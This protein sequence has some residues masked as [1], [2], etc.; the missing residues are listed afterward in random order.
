[1]HRVNHELLAFIG[2]ICIFTALLE[3]WYRRGMRVSWLVSFPAALGT[4]VG[5]AILWIGLLWLAE[6]FH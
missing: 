6:K 5:V 4:V 2:F 1:M 3:P